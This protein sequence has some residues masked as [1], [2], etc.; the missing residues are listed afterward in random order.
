VIQL[1]AEY[2]YSRYS[3]APHELVTKGLTATHLVFNRE[4]L[5]EKVHQIGKPGELGELLGKHSAGIENTVGGNTCVLL[6]R[7]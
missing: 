6:S 3:R 2:K 1:N 5:T 7:S 4:S